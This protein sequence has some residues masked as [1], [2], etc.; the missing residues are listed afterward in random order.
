MSDNCAI[1]YA[2]ELLR[3]EIRSAVSLIPGTEL[4]KINEIRLRSGRYMSVS[5]CDEDLFL[6]RDGFLT[7]SCSNAL[8]CCQDDIDYAFKTAFSYSLHSYSKELAMGFV[9]TRGGNRVGVCGTAVVHDT[10]GVEVESVKYI[11]S[12]NIRIARQVKGFA[13]RLYS[14]CFFDRLSSVLIIGPPASGKTTLLRDLCRLVG[15][16]AKVAL[17]DTQNELSATYRESPQNDVGELTDIFT[18]YPKRAGIETAVRVMSPK[19]VVV[20]EIGTS[21]DL[22][23]LEMA[24]HSGVKL[25]TAVHGN[26]L[27]DAMSKNCVKA[28]MSEHAFDYA[29]ELTGNYSYRVRKIA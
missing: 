15:V 10:H 2:F 25:I 27:E 9:T 21:D 5:K 11:S 4:E 29:A 19:A 22:A 7:H 8:R 12:V 28:L 1:K 3:G 14:E 6:S 23:A 24:L 13:Q 20:D 17:I 18:G 16:S 26:S